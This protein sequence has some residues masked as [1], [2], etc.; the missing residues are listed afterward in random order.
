[1]AKLPTYAR[2]PVSNIIISPMR[3]KVVAEP[4]LNSVGGAT[5]ALMLDSGLLLYDPKTSI[6]SLKD[7]LLH[8]SMHGIW[9]Q[10]YLRYKYPD[11]APD[12]A[13]EKMIGTLSPRVLAFLQDN[14]RLVHWLMGEL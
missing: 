4:T 5:G 7:T 9:A 8:E 14:K 12:S 10:T 3:V 2:S 11:G 1:M 13:G 6:E